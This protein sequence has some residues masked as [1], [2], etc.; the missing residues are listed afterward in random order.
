MKYIT[1]TPLPFSTVEAPEFK[2]FVTTLQPK[3]KVISRPTL[4]LRIHDAAKKMKTE[5]TEKMKAV[6]HVATTTDCWSARRKSFIGVTAHWFDPESLERFSVILACRHLRG[7]HTFDVLAH[8][9]DDIHSE[10]GIRNKIVRTTTD[11]GSNF[12][13]AFQV[14]SAAPDR[15]NNAGGDPEPGW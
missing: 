9:L 11:N 7:S 4:R 13:K 15:N 14:Y 10:Y 12:L 8:A 3:A 6:D 2:E 1:E 5:V